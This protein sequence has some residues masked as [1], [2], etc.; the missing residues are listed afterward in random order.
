METWF[1]IYLFNASAIPLALRVA[2]AFSRR[3]LRGSCGVAAIFMP[4]RLATHVPSLASG[5]K[6]FCLFTSL[7]DLMEE[8]FFQATVHIFI[9]ATGIAVRAIAPCLRH[10]SKD[11]PVLVVDPAGS[12][13]IS[14]LSGHWGG[15][16]RLA[17]QLAGALNAQPVLTTASDVFNGK[18]SLDLLIRDAGLRIL[19]WQETAP[20]QGRILEGHFPLL[21]DPYQLLPGVSWLVP[22]SEG[23]L[24]DAETLI[25]VDIK[26]H[27]AR[28]GLLRAVPPVFHLGF[29][30]RRGVKAEELKEAFESLCAKLELSMEAVVACASVVPKTEDPEAKKFALSINADLK[31]FPAEALAAIPTPNP[32][33]ACGRRFSRRPFSVSESAAL[34]SASLT[35]PK[36]HSTGMGSPVLSAFLFAEKHIFNK[37]IT[38]ALAVPEYFHGHSLSGIFQLSFPAGGYGKK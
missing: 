10:K 20:L 36:A 18:R 33:P 32:S 24:D 3:Q 22:V 25:C 12:Y 17:R 8:N 30:F 2:E 5:G 14:L 38:M 21:H 7:K 23:P 15:A 28:A 11:P 1:A 19:D 26:R 37:T 16:N 31:S 35:H 29:G 13:V 34:M 27:K 9:G 6:I 4:Q